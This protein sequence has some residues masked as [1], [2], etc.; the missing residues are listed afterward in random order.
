MR[1]YWRGLGLLG[2]ALAL[3]GCGAGEQAAGT[4]SA[5]TGPRLVLAA[6][7]TVDWRDVSAEVATV[8]QAQL[9]ARIPGI[10]TEFTVREGD[11]VAKGQAIGRI[12]DS[13]L[14]PQAGAYGAQAEAARAQAAQAQ[15]ELS[16]VRFL[17]DNGVYARARLEQ[18]QAAAD[19]AA[20][21]LRAVRAQQSAVGALAGQGTVIAPASGRVLRADIPAGSPVA[22]GMVLAVITAGPT[23]LRLAMPESLGDKVRTG[24]RVIAS[25]ITTGQASGRVVRLYPS[26]SGGQAIAEAEMPGLDGRLIGRRVAAKVETGTRKALLVPASYVVTRFGIDYVMTV[27]KDGSAAQVPVQT[28]P[29]TEAGKVEILSGVAAG[30][31][32]AA[33]LPAGTRGR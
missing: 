8:D 3:A 16:R 17:H 15:A 30:D 11:R 24:S 14:A 13:Q 12:V 27:A 7:E 29:S 22:P 9:L 25:G 6:S 26:V 31:V 2:A 19:A 10:L 28:A 4:D 23:I 20:A 32:L 21:Q 1:T 33:P 5:P 18:A